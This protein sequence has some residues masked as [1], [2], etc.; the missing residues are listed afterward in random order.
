M[1][2]DA[3]EVKIR[4]IAG[5]ELTNAIMQNREGKIKVTPGFDGEYGK[6][7]WLSDK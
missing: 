1:L 5:R 2:L 3:D 4:E 7:Q 6:L